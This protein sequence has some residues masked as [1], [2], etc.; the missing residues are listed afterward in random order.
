MTFLKKSFRNVYLKKIILKEVTL[1]RIRYDAILDTVKRSD[2]SGQDV[3]EP[4]IYSHIRDLR[5][6]AFSC[7]SPPCDLVAGGS[8]NC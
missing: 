3:Y 6:N 5:K 8:A 2:W 7:C 4:R 1:H